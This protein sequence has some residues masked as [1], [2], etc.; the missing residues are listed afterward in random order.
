MNRLIQIQ[1]EAR[2]D[3]LFKSFDLFPIVYRCPPATVCT[4]LVQSSKDW[5]SKRGLLLRTKALNHRHIATKQ[6]C[7]SKMLRGTPLDPFTSM[8]CVGCGRYDYHETDQTTRPRGQQCV[9]TP[10][11]HFS[12]FLP[13]F[14]FFTLL[15][16]PFSASILP[17]QPS[18]LLVP[19]SSSRLTPRLSFLLVPTSS[20]SSTV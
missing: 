15:N 17:P 14:H 12:F 18:F 3:S 9:L 6:I 11:F 2:Y 13:L 10:L 5:Q 4:S 19:A 8:H 7:G 1:Y 16:A 20:S